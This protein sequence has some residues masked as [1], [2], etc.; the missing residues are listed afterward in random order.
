MTVDSAEKLEIFESIAIFSGLPATDLAVIAECAAT[1]SFKKNAI[2]MNEGDRADS[3][4]LILN[5]KVRVYVSND[6]SNTEVTLNILGPGGYFGELALLDEGSRSASVMTLEP[7]RLAIVSKVDFE[8][9]LSNNPAIA[10]NLIRAL[11]YRIRAL[12]DKV[13][14]LALLDVY[15]RVARTLLNLAEEREGRQVIGQKLTYQEIASMIGASHRMVS[16]I[17]KDLTTGGYITVKDKKITI[18][19]RLPPRW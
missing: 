2:L 5:G 3:L 1:R 15:G 12:T 18:N 6:E 16:R 7:T 4:Y 13:G 11:V 17:M 19:D 9:C 8:Q 10:L 14:T